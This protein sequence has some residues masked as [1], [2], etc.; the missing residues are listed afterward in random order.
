M[1]SISVAIKNAARQ[2]YIYWDTADTRHPLYGRVEVA[3]DQT[4][5]EQ[6]VREVAADPDTTIT[7]LK[8]DGAKR[9]ITRLLNE[10]GY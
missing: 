4:A 7:D 2:T 1:T 6:R 3:V 8:M 5:A 9:S 10:R